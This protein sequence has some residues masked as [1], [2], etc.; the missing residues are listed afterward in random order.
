MLGL[1]PTQMGRLMG[2]AYKHYIR[3]E[4]GEREPTAQHTAALNLINAIHENQSISDL[5]DCGA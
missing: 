3:L 5:V 2:M 1:N 4:N